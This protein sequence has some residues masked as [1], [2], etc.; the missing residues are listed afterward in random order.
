[1]SILL[2]LLLALTMSGCAA[3]VPTPIETPI[4]VETPEVTFSESMVTEDNFNKITNGMTYKEVVNI[5]GEEG[6]HKLP[7]TETI[8]YKW[9]NMDYDHVNMKPTFY[10]AWIDFQ[11]D[12]VVNKWWR[13]RESLNE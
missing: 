12:K 1:M 5:F 4:S 3:E 7:N 2:A 6:T 8:T 11:D 9:S 13:I 10:E